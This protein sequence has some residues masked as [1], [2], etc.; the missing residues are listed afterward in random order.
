MVVE[1]ED[2]ADLFLGGS[3]GHGA[4]LGHLGRLRHFGGGEGLRAETA[5]GVDAAT[6]TEVEVLRRAVSPW[7]PSWEP[8]SVDPTGHAWTPVDSKACRFGLCGRLWTRLDTAWRSTDQKVGGSSPPERAAT[9][10]AEGPDGLVLHFV[11]LL[12]ALVMQITEAVS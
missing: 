2:V 8:F 12:I 4:S 11:V 1:G 9:C 7:E 5:G 6:L 3:I 10:A